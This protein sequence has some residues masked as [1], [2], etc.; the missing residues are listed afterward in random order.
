MFWVNSVYFL[1]CFSRNFLP[2][3]S[4]R[5]KCQVNQ[6]ISLIYLTFWLISLVSL[7]F[8][9]YCHTSSGSIHVVG[10]RQQ[11]CIKPTGFLV[12]QKISHC[13]SRIIQT[14]YPWCSTRNTHTLLPWDWVQ[15]THTH[16]C[17]LVSVPHSR[18]KF[19]QFHAIVHK[20]LQ[21]CMLVNPLSRTGGVL[22]YG[23]SWINP[24]VCTTSQHTRTLY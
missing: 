14:F 11:L 24:C 6:Q 12:Y 19:T 18:P 1:Y 13:G 9:F 15:Q 5:S 16:A 3:W 22:L 4:L 10:M 8:E 21:N 17:L 20:I 23:E 7:T 2:L